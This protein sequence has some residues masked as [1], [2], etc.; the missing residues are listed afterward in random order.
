MKKLLLIA[1]LIVGCAP[2]SS[3]LQS[4]KLVGKGKYEITPHLSK[5]YVRGED[6]GDI[7]G[8]IQTHYGAQI[9][10]GLTKKIDFR[11]R[12]EIIKMSDEVTD[13][14]IRYRMFTLGGKYSIIS[15]RM[16]F[17]LPVSFYKRID[18][19]D[20]DFFKTIAPTVL[21]TKYLN[22]YLDFN[23]SVK[24]IFPFLEGAAEGFYYAVN[25][26]FG[27][28]LKYLKNYKFQNWIIR[29]EMGILSHSQSDGDGFYQHMSLGLSYRFRL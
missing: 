8:A 24:L 13:D 19:E 16:S 6:S 28:K 25:L 9:A 2:V 26:G 14:D 15:N 12:I 7:D 3:D 11:S 4:A 22:G 10:Y 1:L 17:Y 29:P 27:I 5:I 20:C 18:C 23:H 21:F